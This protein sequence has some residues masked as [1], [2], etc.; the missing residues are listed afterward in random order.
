MPL[1]GQCIVRATRRAGQMILLVRPVFYQLQPPR[2]SL[3]AFVCCGRHLNADT[4]LHTSFATSTAAARGRRTW[5][6]GLSVFAALEKRTN[7]PAAKL[8]RAT[9]SAQAKA[10]RCAVNSP[11]T[12][13]HSPCFLLHCFLLHCNH[14][15]WLRRVHNACDTCVRTS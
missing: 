5:S 14:F 13:T 9:Q 1:F 7:T 12:H 15:M 3:S 4:T 8:T 11:L 6:L 2:V 10:A